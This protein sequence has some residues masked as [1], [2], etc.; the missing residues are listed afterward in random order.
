MKK[1]A[2]VFITLFL[3]LLGTGV[4]SYAESEQVKEIL[5]VYSCPETQIITDKNNSKELVDTVIY[6]YT[7]F[8]Y[9]QYVIHDNRYEVY[10]EGTFRLNFDWKE[11]GWQFVSPHIITIHAE[12]IHQADHQLDTDSLNYDINLDNVANYCLYPDNVRTDLKLAAAF[13]Q[14]DKQKMEKS[15]GTVLY[16]PTMWFYYDDHSFQQYVLLDE[17]EDLLFSTGEY[18]ISEGGFAAEGSVLTLHRTQKY[19]DGEGLAAYDSTHEYEIGSLG[20]IR[21]YPDLEISK[22]EGIDK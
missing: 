6:L 20:F 17:Q 16:L 4:A 15:D 10:S 21:I 2:F 7:D 5:A 3:A 1:K 13:M 18:T 19:R 12:T 8:T 9:I 11:K 22:A 14:V